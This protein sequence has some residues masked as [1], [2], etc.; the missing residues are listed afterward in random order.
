MALHIDHTVLF[1]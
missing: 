1:M